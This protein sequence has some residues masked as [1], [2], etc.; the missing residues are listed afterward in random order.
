MVER[1]LR[2]DVGAVEAGL[3]DFVLRG[4]GLGR[5]HVGLLAGL[6]HRVADDVRD[7]LLG[8][9]VGDRELLVVA[10]P[11][12]VVAEY[13]AG[14][15]DEAEGLFH[16]ALAVASLRVI[17]PDEPA[18][19][20]PDLLVR[21]GLRYAQRFV[22]R[23]SHRVGGVERAVRSRNIRLKALRN[24]EEVARSTPNPVESAQVAHKAQGQPES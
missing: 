3:E 20:G 9:A 21:G 22:E 8:G 15:I 10:D 12:L 16:I 18:Q 11:P 6:R 19:R 5:L 7:L 4:L 2:R 1:A 17:F 13:A 14:M 24:Q 23:R